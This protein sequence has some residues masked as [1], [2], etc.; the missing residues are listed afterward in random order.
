MK[1]SKAIADDLDAI[2]KA[3]II[4]SLG[5]HEFTLGMFA[6]NYGISRETAESIINDLVKAN[7]IAYVGLRKS[8]RTPSRA[9]TLTAKIKK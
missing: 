5:E 9:Y 2:V 7:R 1:L 4:P 3:R 6:E 8:G